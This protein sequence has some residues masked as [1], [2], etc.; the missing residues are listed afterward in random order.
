MIILFKY[1]EEKRVKV[2]KSW[3]ISVQKMFFVF[4]RFM[5]FLILVQGFLSP[6]SFNIFK[7]FFV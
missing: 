4:S 3:N 5:T 6:G 1:T 2:Q 7:F